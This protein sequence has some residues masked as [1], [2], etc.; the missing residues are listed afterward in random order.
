MPLQS[1][2]QQ[3]TSR[4]GIPSLHCN[5]LNCSSIIGALFFLIIV[6]IGHRYQPSSCHGIAEFHCILYFP[7]DIHY[8]QS[9]S[10]HRIPAFHCNALLL[11]SSIIVLSMSVVFP[12]THYCC[13]CPVVCIVLHCFSWPYIIII[14]TFIVHNVSVCHHYSLFFVIQSLV[15]LIDMP[16]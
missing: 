2:A 6:G 10:H 12:L 15:V 4:R 13:F 7:I 8:Y 14:F 11:G 16:P 1:C 9:T 5:D 3:P